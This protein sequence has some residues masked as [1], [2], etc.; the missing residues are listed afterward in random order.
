MI[1]SPSTNSPL[2]VAEQHAVGVAIMGDTDVGS[3]LLD[4]S[5]N[6]RRI[7]AAAISR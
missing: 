7:R 4:G 6:L 3:G 2:L 5:L 1:S